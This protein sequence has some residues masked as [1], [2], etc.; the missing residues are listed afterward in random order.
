MAQKILSID[1][2][3][4]RARSYAHKGEVD[5]ARELYR[6]V[7]EAFPKDQQARAGLKA[8]PSD[9]G[10]KPAPGFTKEQLDD[11]IALYSE[12]RLQ[13]AM[14]A[15]Q[16]LIDR[17]SNAPILHNLAGT[18]HAESGRLDEAVENYRKAL[19]I[20]PDYAEVHNNLGNALRKLSKPG[21]A[22][23][24][25][26]RALEINPDF[27]E[28]NYNLGAALGELGKHEEAAGS[29][30]RALEI[31]P[32][33][34][35]PCN[36]LG[37]SLRNLGRLEE[38][39]A[40]YRRALEIKPDYAEAHYNLGEA[41]V[42][43]GKH[44]EAVSSYRRTVALK[45]EFAEAQN[46]IAGVLKELGRYEE[47]I[48]SYHKALEIDRSSPK[49][50]YNLGLILLLKG[51]FEGGWK[52]HEWR[53]RTQS[54]AARQFFQ[55]V[56]RGEALR[57]KKILIWL[58]QGIGDEVMFASMLTDVAALASQCCVECDPR[59]ESLLKRSYP[60]VHVIPRI[61]PA[62]P[63]ACSTDISYQVAAGSL[64]QWFRRNLQQFPGHHGYLKPDQRR[65]DH[66]RQKYRDWSKGRTVVGLSWR[67]GNPVGSR[68]KKR[69]LPLDQWAPIL[70]DP[71]IAFVNVQYGDC[72]SEIAA[73]ARDFGVDI[74]Q[75]DEIDAF[76]ELDGLAAQLTAL[77]LTISIDNST[78]H[79]AGALGR[80]VWVLLPYACDWRWLIDR[81]DSPWYPTARLF[82]QPVIGDWA[83]VI[84]RV[85][86]EL[87]KLIEGR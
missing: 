73:I 44:E 52:E 18:I 32:D 66:L 42:E 79:L 11:V 81:E 63:R 24:C 57:G 46:N 10:K 72:E 82:R 65:V 83:S 28:A 26:H 25:Y 74:Y 14:S 12:G 43:L 78:V 67:S 49:F 21:E 56:W 35:A 55:P 3:L 61:N 7:L 64:G 13:E 51:D 48:A 54:I 20:N 62:D 70:T 23:A 75:D 37:V 27:A 34:A 41:L 50:H 85:N 6:A 59:L 86:G 68:R 30:R 80:P 8:L 16:R 36:N 45:P 38:A 60:D 22:V 58:E 53:F 47:A 19:Q 87:S 17:D 69:T 5:Q 39:V 2:A 9:G 76:T 1:Q 15:V 4:A 40:S 33:Y 29:Y 77:D 31:K 84:A 71:R